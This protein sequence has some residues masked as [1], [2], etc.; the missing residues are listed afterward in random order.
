MLSE[1]PLLSHFSLGPCEE[2]LMIS[3]FLMGK[4]G[5]QPGVVAYTC[6]LR[7]CWMEASE[8][9]GHSWLWRSDQNT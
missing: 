8:I 6:G 3:A 2:D 5:G 9:Q 4:K 7:T 1:D